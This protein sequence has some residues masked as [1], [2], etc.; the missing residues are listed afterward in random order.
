MLT[1]GNNDVPHVIGISD[2]DKPYFELNFCRIQ[3]SAYLGS[4]YRMSHFSIVVCGVYLASYLVSKT[5]LVAFFSTQ[6]LTLSQTTMLTVLSICWV[7][8]LNAPLRLFLSLA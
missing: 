3:I 8:G 4:K 7:S 6:G 5:L 2:L 1:L